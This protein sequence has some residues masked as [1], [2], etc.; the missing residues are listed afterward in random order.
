MHSRPRLE[1]IEWRVTPANNVEVLNDT[2][3]LYRY[4]DAT[5]QAEFLY[6][7]V[8]QTIEET[9]PEEINYLRRYDVMKEYLNNRFDRPDNLINLIIR[10]L[11]QNS[12]KFSERARKKELKA[13][14]EAELAGIEE[15]WVRGL[16]I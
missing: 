13:F 10:F 5:K 8:K 11:D 4:Y 12:G 1:Y 16:E 15:E 14:T 6:D 3:D 2:I 7:C 9:L